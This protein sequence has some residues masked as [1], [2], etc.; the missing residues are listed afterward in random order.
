VTGCN[1][2][3][4]GVPHAA[5]VALLSNA[6][7]KPLTYLIPDAL[8]GKVTPGV[9]VAVPLQKKLTTGVV[10]DVGQA[11]APLDLKP[12]HALLDDKPALTPAQLALARWI[13]DEYYASLGRCCAL[14]VPPGFTA[15]SA[16]VYALAT[17]D[18]KRKTQDHVAV[19]PRSSSVTTADRIIEVLR[20][21]GP[22][23]ESK[24]SAAMKGIIAWRGTLK[25]LV[26]EGT[27]VRSSTL[28]PPVAQPRKT[29]L[30]QL[31]IGDAT[32]ELVLANLQSNRKL[33]PQVKARRAEVL[34]YLQ[35]RSG[36]AWADWIFAETGA[37][38]ADLIWLAEQ[39][40]LILG[41]AERWRDPLADIDYV[42]KTAPPLTE[43]QQRA[44]DAIKLKIENEK[45]TKGES[46]SQFS[47]FNSQF[48]LRGV[49]GSGKTEIYMRAV[50]AVLRQG[51]GAIVLVPE[52][53][54]TP[55][56]ARRFLERFP[57]RV[58][59]I[60]SKLKPGER[61]DTWRRIRSGEL[62]V[63]V[64]ARSALFAPV[65]NPGLIVLDE[66]HDPSYKQTSSPWYDARRVA[67]QYAELTG[68]TLI[69]GSATPSL[70][71]WYHIS[72]VKVS[73]DN[74]TPDN[75]TLLELPNR[76]RG[77]A[78]R[79][80]QQGVR[81]GVHATAE[82]E[83]EAV[84]YQSLP[85][86]QVIDMRAELRGGNAGM[87]S[88]V[89]FNALGETLRRGE[90]AIL[91]LNRRGTASSVICRDCGHAMRCPNDDTPLTLHVD[92]ERR[93]T[94][95][96]RQ[97]SI[98]NRQSLRCHQCDYTEPA[99]AK[100][101][102]CGSAR[103]RFIGIGTQRI[104]Q[105]IARHFP[106]ARVVRWDRDTASKASA[107]QMLQR[108]VNRQADVLVGTQ[109]IAKG[110]D[111]P[112]VTLV[113]VVLADVGL[114]LPDFRASERVFNLLAQVAGRAGRGLLPGRVIVQTYNP[115]QP[116]IAFAGQ[117]DVQGF[118]R[119]ELA[120]RKLLN[121]PPFTRLIRFEFDAEAEADAR[122]ACELLARQLR[123]RVP[124]PTD[125]I[126]PAQ[127]Y[128]TRR[129]KRYRWQVLVRTHSPRELLEGL[130]IPRGWVVDVD[131]ISVL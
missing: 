83:A 115:E 118:V 55:Q 109:M 126:G 42:P 40:Y 20:L 35:A 85:A 100:C 32:L 29:S 130:D 81:L 131:P 49:T 103:I 18:A 94:D 13:S 1:D 26:K 45:L 38:R 27:V 21:R 82:R 37:N 124:K 44:W 59:L 111:L 33:Q 125:V 119:Y 51:R 17:E 2:Y 76:V 64:G 79:I 7:D 75:L 74:L 90:Q 95:D 48:L 63:V 120:Q 72:S 31:A 67:R 54:L 10:V 88:G 121:L 8:A 43:D 23:V 93:T 128:F 123:A 127:A 56:T 15:K 57:G 16:W 112:L 30:A 122:L 104:E 89:L 46:L 5:S 60:H 11:Q 91:F 36:I 108:F 92:D 116:A 96:G 68:A 71:S 129:N 62:P 6:I 14:M 69:F 61:F 25:R 86:V 97:S 77:H 28:K 22:L 9:V 34:T 84:A 24:L 114:F 78:T 58:A 47:I 117:H 53:S 105:E 66:E 99:P 98:V 113:G 87:F 65:P 110:L 102:A 41:D 106:Q 52:I 19:S 50:E 4:D 107:D 39:G 101:P 3:N 70:E 80:E 12:I 73:R